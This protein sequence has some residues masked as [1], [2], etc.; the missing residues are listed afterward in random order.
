MSNNVNK[1]QFT[2]IDLLIIYSWAAYNLAKKLIFWA[3]LKKNAIK[4]RD[5]FL[6][7]WRQFWNKNAA[8]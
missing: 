4:L 1:C 5:L 3:W 7:I 8:N 2:T 6:Q